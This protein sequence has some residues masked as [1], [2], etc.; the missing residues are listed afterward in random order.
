M[1]DTYILTD[2]IKFAVMVPLSV[3]D[4]IYVTKPTGGMYEVEPLLFNTKS[5][6]EEHAAIWGSLARVVEYQQEEL[7]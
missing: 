7:Q 2:P 3:D 6:A 4:Y 1:T 5:E